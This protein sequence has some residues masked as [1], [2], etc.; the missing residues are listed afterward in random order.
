VPF[1]DANGEPLTPEQ[2]LGLAREIERETGQKLT[3][4]RGERRRAP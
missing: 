1:R 4:R 3:F 2:V